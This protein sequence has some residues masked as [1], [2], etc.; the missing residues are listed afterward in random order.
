MI[1][2]LHRL[3]AIWGPSGHEHKI[4]AVIAEAL[5]P[6]V[7]QVWTD[8]YGNVIGKRNGAVGGHKVMLVSHMDTSGAMALNIAESGLIYL[9]PIGGL[10]V[11]HA[12]GQRVVWGTG[13][14]GVLQHEPT[15]DPRE[16]DF[17]KLWCDLGASTRQ[18]VAENLRL[19][20]MCTLSGDLWHM[21]ELLCGPGLD[22]RAGCAALM[23]VAERLEHPRHDLYF[24]FTCQGQV[25][26]R[27]AGPAAFGINPDLAFVVDFATG[28]DGPRAARSHAQLGKGPVLKLKEANFMAH[29]GLVDL[30]QG[31]ATQH[32]IALQVVV[33]GT[34]SSQTEGL[35]VST[36]HGGIPVGLLE[37]PG[38]YRGTAGEV[39][40]IGDLH[41]TVDLLLKL[42]SDPL[43][44]N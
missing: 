5:A 42:L 41:G 3:A 44:L 4:A 35:A 24:A 1:E 19:G 34:E 7:D 15:D 16:L 10:K 18:A 26:A 33:G 13:A 2:I 43:D 39:I 12:I 21:G 28:G 38:R 25:S 23:A 30:I 17:K 14:V 31:V 6:L 9:T 20:D 8:R 27:G 11:H 40:N 22:N 32:S 37:I 36:A 29:Q